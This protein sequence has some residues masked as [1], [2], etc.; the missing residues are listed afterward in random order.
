VGWPSDSMTPQAR[1]AQKKQTDLATANT[2]PF[3][4]SGFLA[5]FEF[6]LRVSYFKATL[7]RGEISQHTD[8]RKFDGG[9]MMTVD[10][11]AA[12]VGELRSLLKEA[13]APESFASICIFKTRR[14][15][16]TS[17]PLYR[18]RII[19]ILWT[20]PT[21]VTQPQLGILQITPIRNIRTHEIDSALASSLIRFRIQMPDTEIK[22]NCEGGPNS[23]RYGLALQAINSLFASCLAISEHR[24]ERWPKFEKETIDAV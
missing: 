6:G 9:M 16:R 4:R 10:C 19:C 7:Y 13:T 15:R 24:Q 17:C 12:F 23:K 11:S 20:E 5:H 2:R 1:V 22:D 21:V 8:F 18:P 3:H 14:L